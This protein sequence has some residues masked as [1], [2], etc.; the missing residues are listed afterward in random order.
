MQALSW[1]ALCRFRLAPPRDKLVRSPEVQHDYD[2]YKSQNC[3]EMAVGIAERLSKLRGCSANLFPA[4][5]N[6]VVAVNNFPYWCEGN[7]RH[8]VVWAES[9]NHFTYIRQVLE[10]TLGAE[11][12][13]LFCNLENNKSIQELPHLHLFVKNSELAA[14]LS[15]V[16]L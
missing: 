15:P 7:I 12:L 10:S 6:T 14:K 1:N 8:L 3:G 9:E 2:H 4:A 5:P 13:V 16:L 11:N